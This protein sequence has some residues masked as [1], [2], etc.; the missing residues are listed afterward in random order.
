MA[1]TGDPKDTKPT[2]RVCLDVNVWIAHLLA[3]QNERRGGSASALVNIVRE[4]ECAAGPVQLVMS[5]EMIATLEKVLTRLGFDQESISDF[6][7]SLTGIM[8]TGPERFDPHLLP[9]GGRH[10]AMRDIEDAGILASSIATR[11]DLIVT[12]NLNDFIIKGSSRVDTR[13]VLLPGQPARQLFALVYD[14]NDGV[15][16]VIA[17]PI[18]ALDW[19]RQGL[20]PTSEAIK[21]LVSNP[22]WKP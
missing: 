5:W 7:S 16:I 18:D 11:V 8:R 3:I 22:T 12:N 4:M 20:R 9:E 21:N 14:R 2:I 6:T 1:Q 10:L 19:L 13:E 17:H 15:S